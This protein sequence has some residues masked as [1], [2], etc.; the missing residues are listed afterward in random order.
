[1]L[2]LKLSNHEEMEIS[3]ITECISTDLGFV[4][5]Y[6]CININCNNPNAPNNISS[7]SDKFSDVV[8]LTPLTII[9]YPETI[10]GDN[11]TYGN[12]ENVLITSQYTK[13][14][15]IYKNYSNNLITIT[16]AK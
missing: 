8:L 16:L 1:M 6:I 9:R 3:E 2:K 10:E 13:L 7:L 11:I 5:N 12:P 4:Q 15:S 14:K